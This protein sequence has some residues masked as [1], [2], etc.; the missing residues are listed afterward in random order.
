MILIFDSVM[1][2]KGEN[3]FQHFNT[4]E[5]IWKIHPLLKIS[6]SDSIHHLKE[7]CSFF[8][9]FIIS[10][11]NQ[12]FPLIFEPLLISTRPDPP[13][14]TRTMQTN[15][16]TVCHKMETLS[17]AWYLFFTLKNCNYCWNPSWI[18]RGCLQEIDKYVGRKEYMTLV[19]SIHLLLFI[20]HK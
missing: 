12:T 5:K 8:K 1:F 18:V 9:T 19:F 17:W 13:E 2:W 7:P 3:I 4:V 6:H 11:S 16:I 10:F 20:I 14:L 15:L